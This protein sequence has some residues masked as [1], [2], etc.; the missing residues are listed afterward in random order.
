M[1]LGLTS[2]LTPPS[3]A[4]PSIAMAKMANAF[5]AFMT[6]A[7]VAEVGICADYSIGAPDGSWDLQTKFSNWVSSKEFLPGDNLSILRFR[8]C[9]FLSLFVFCIFV[10]VKFI[11]A[12]NARFSS[13]QSCA[14]LAKCSCLIFSKEKLPLI[15]FNSFDSRTNIYSSHFENRIRTGNVNRGKCNT[16]SILLDSIC[17]I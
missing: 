17:S 16:I 2:W 3:S 4:A 12:N 8:A 10:I 9:P 1:V 5:I 6:M 15:I 14:L 7:A 13:S 11:E